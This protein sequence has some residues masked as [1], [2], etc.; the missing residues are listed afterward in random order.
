MCWRNE[1]MDPPSIVIPDEWR[2]VADKRPELWLYSLWFDA[3]TL[4]QSFGQ[5]RTLI[6]IKFV[7]TMDLPAF[8][9][10]LWEGY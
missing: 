6:S 8:P 7:K 4:L 3:A 10:S 5:K 2:P 1:F 9:D